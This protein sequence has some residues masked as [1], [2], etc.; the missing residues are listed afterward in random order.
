MRYLKFF[1]SFNSEYDVVI[2]GGGIAGLYTAYLL[3]K[4]NKSFLLIERD[5]QLG[6]RIKMD[7]IND[8]DI[9]TGA[10][11]LRWDKDKSLIKLINDLDIKISP[12]ELKMDKTF[13]ESDIDKI[14]KKL[15]SNLKDYS[16]D[17]INFKKYAT[18]VL[19]K[20]DYQ[21]LINMM[22]YSDFEKADFEDT[23]MNYGLDDNVSGNKMVN[24]DCNKLISKLVKSIG[25]KRIVLNKEVKD[26]KSINNSF[27]IDCGDK[28]TCKKVIVATQISSV[29]KLIKKDIYKE[30]ESQE[31]IKIFAKVD[32]LESVKNYTI[33]DS[34]LRIVIPVKN[35][36]YCIAFSDNKD[37]IYLNNQNNSQIEKLLKVN[38]DIKGISNMKKFFWEEGTHY[39][40]PLSNDWK[41][42]K[43]FIKNAQRPD[44]NIFV[45]GECVA[46]KQGW[47][48][49]ALETVDSVIDEIKK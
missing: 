17:K 7:E 9:P 1:E 11:Y 36:V 31:F 48:N 41:S 34:P 10:A 47:V 42:R 4:T 23:V 18:E 3:S 14:F 20:E 22:G 16:R 44:K 15:K 6:G 27:I 25:N 38:F 49:G 2:I 28:I 33:V 24:I 30:I 5:S 35:D 8:V 46:Q 29:K 39:Y 26:I 45:V 37:A 40:K 21:N 32:G 13:Q 12:Y 19:G 43:E